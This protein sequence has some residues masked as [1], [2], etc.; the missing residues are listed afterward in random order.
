MGRTTYMHKD[1]QSLRAQVWS[2]G[3]PTGSHHEP[4]QLDGSHQRLRACP[5]S[6]THTR[7]HTHTCLPGESKQRRHLLYCMTSDTGYHIHA[8]S[9]FWSYHSSRWTQTSGYRFL[10]L[11]SAAAV[12]FRCRWQTGI[13]T[14]FINNDF[15]FIFFF[16]CCNCRCIYLMLLVPVTMKTATVI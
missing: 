12:A 3:T 15:V 7:T 6:L 13:V 10:A 1:A 5:T 2:E 9:D 4:I 11:R 16:C 14:K 8:S